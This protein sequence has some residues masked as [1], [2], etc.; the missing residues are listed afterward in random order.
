MSAPQAAS[1][2]N[3]GYMC[4]KPGLSSRKQQKL[5][6]LRTPQAPL[7]LFGTLKSQWKFE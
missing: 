7:V 5:P 2:Y 3:N 1:N 4:F 6:V